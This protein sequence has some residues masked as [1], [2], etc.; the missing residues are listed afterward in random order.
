MANENCLTGIGAIFTCSNASLNFPSGAN[1]IIPRRISGLGRS[2]II[3]DDSDLTLA[4]NGPEQYCPG[5]LV[6][7]RPI[8]VDVKQDV[9]NTTI[10]P[11][12]AHGAAAQ[13]VPVPL[14]ISSGT[15]SPF[16]L[17]FPSTETTGFTITF[18]GFFND[19]SGI[20]LVKTNRHNGTLQIQPDGQLF[21]T[22]AASSV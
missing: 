17:Q 22:T 21:T 9:D 14:G 12:A 1:Q 18:S 2:V 15:V 16:T 10:F 4:E 20:E 8:S 11:T 7:L 3:I 5:D 6:Q 13:A 19:D